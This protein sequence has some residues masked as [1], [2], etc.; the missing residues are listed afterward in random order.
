MLWGGSN[1]PSKVRLPYSYI[2]TV[3]HVAQ[4]APNLQQ[5]LAWSRRYIKGRQLL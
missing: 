4:V 5:I 3:L 2:K 1:T